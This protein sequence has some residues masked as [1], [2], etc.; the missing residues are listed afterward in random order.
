MAERFA[1]SYAAQLHATFVIPKR[2]KKEQEAAAAGG[3]AAKHELAEHTSA[4]GDELSLLIVRQSVPY[5]SFNN[6][7]N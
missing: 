4:R 6:A 3:H 1:K 2:W 5:T 7:S